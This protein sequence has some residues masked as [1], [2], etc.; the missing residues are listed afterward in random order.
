MRDLGH[1][2]E[3]NAFSPLEKTVIEYAVHMTDT[4][5]EVPEV[6]FEGLRQYY[7]DAQI[8]EI[9]AALAWENYRTRFNHALGIESQGFSEGAYCSLPES[10]RRLDV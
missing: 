1:Y 5:V 7:N 8:V 3:S 9:T 2:E 10:G 6:L 4:P